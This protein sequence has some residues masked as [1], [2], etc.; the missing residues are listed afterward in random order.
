MN[1]TLCTSVLLTSAY[2]MCISKAPRPHST[3]SIGWVVPVSSMAPSR[4]YST[5]IKV[6]SY[7]QYMKRKIKPPPSP[8]Y[9][10]VCQVGDPV[11]RAQAAVVDPGSVQGPEV[12][13]VIH[14]MVK[15]MRKFECVGL[16]APQVGVPLRILAL[17]FPERMLEDSLP[18]AREARGLTTVPLRIFI[19]PQLR[20]L[21]GRTVL[22][23]EAC[24]N[25]KAEPVTWQVSGWP[26]RIL[27][28]EMD[29]LDGVL[30]IDR[31]D[32]KTFINVNWAAKIE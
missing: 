8:P 22:F 14:T 3:G 10:H 20:V 12:Q 7:L 11:L 23:Q 18:A 13:E 2:R 30:Y 16:S 28:H 1:R 25:E 5:N 9:P 17:E 27:Q 6:R 31:M 29:H 26:A 32:S 15:V 19:N 4:S 21:D 24:L